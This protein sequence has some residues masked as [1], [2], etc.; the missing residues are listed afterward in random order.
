MPDLTFS[1]SAAEVAPFAAVPLLLFKL[2]IANAPAGQEIASITLQCQIQIEATRRRYS[3]AE[4]DGLQDL[5]GV[6]QR[7]AQTLR[8][9]L[10]TH[11]TVIVPAFSGTCVIDLPVPC[12]FDFNIAATKYCH[13]LQDG[14]IPL[15]LQFSG[16][17]FYRNADDALQAAPV[18][19][20]K[21]AAFRLPVAVWQDMMA[22]YYPNGAWLC[23]QRE[24]F[25]RLGRYK[26]Q[27]GLAT[28]ERALDALLDGA[29]EK[30]S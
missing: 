3:P 4:H 28:W 16:T 8:T 15:M 24:V 10:W 22:R 1:I 25:D 26:A 9:M 13:A 21:E 18:P 6:P 12:S 14:E 19:W 30:A 17:V 5:F 2:Q 29:E 20:H 23:L 7:W 11:A 27:Q